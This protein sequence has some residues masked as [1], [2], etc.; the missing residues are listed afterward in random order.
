MSLPTR[1]QAYAFLE[2]FRD[3]STIFLVTSR[4]AHT[5]LSYFVLGC[6]AASRMRVAV[7]DTSCLYGVNIGRLASTLPKEFLQQ[8]TLLHMSDGLEEEGLLAEMV[9]A[10]VPAILI[11]DLNALLQLLSSQGQRSGIHRLSTFYH[12]LSYNA[13]VNKLLALGVAYRTDFAGFSN[14]STRRSLPKMSDLQVTTDVRNDEIVFQC[15]DIGT[16]PSD[17]FRVPL[18]FEER[19]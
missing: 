9:A 1:R 13:R 10:E 19:T 17:G 2:P 3:K 16:W 11:D 5:T 18:Y 7:L 6:L 15:G 8:S 12:V 4:K 14:R